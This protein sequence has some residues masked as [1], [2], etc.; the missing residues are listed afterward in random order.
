MA[1][2]TVDW[3]ARLRELAAARNDPRTV[4]TLLRR[5]ADQIAASDRASTI[6]A[7]D[8]AA[9]AAAARLEE[10][11]VPWW[12]RNPE[13]WEPQ[14]REKVEALWDDSDPDQVAWALMEPVKPE[15]ARWRVERGGDSF[16]LWGNE[17]TQTWN[18]VMEAVRSGCPQGLRA[19]PKL[20]RAHFTEFQDV[21]SLDARQFVALVLRCDQ[22]NARRHKFSRELH[23]VG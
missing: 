15:G 16:M 4:D 11:P 13:M 20:A 5:A 2:P 18:R 8:R 1:K 6:I 12:R 7:R 17:Q 21:D 3:E 9:T 10:R 22:A 14:I 23:T 19:A